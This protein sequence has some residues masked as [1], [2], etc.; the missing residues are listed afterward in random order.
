MIPTRCPS[1]QRS[2][3]DHCAGNLIPR[4]ERAGFWS[5]ATDGRLLGPFNPILTSPA[6]GGLLAFMDAESASTTLDDRTRQIVILAVGAVWRAAYE[7]Y[8]HSA[9]PGG[10]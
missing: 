4:A 1:K 10:A 8:A 6:V 9:E 5:S 7:L 2:L 3:F